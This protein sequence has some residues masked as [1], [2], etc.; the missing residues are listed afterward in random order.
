MSAESTIARIQMKCSQTRKLKEAKS[1]VWIQRSERKKERRMR[2]RNRSP[3]PSERKAENENRQEL[4]QFTAWRVCERY[5]A[6]HSTAQHN[7]ARKTE[8]KLIKISTWTCFPPLHSFSHKN[9]IIMLLN[10]VL[11]LRRHNKYTQLCVRVCV[12]IYKRWEIEMLNQTIATTEEKT[13]FISEMWQE[14]TQ[15]A[16]QNQTQTQANEWIFNWSI[17]NR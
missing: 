9:D 13:R 12:C 11:F 6:A 5:T 15:N 8:D 3:E 4:K 7:T 14:W 2:A 17:F 16:K 10:A 1:K